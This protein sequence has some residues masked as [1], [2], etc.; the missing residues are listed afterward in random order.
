MMLDL[1]WGYW[2]WTI[3]GLPLRMMI[4]KQLGMLELIVVFGVMM[5][6]C[7]ALCCIKVVAISELTEWKFNAY[8]AVDDAACSEGEKERTI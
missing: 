2:W 1:C 3:P 6:I 7:G 4:L 5:M 8:T